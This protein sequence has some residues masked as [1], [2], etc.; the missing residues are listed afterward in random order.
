SVEG[1]LNAVINC[2]APSPIMTSHNSEVPHNGVYDYELGTLFLNL[3][4]PGTITPGN[5]TGNINWNLES[6]P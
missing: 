5:Y 2:S 4:D 3:T 1:E 6:T